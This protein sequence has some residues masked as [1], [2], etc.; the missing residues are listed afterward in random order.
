DASQGSLVKSDPEMVEHLRAAYAMQERKLE[1]PAVEPIA[2]SG[3][4]E[5]PV[6][7]PSKGAGKPPRSKASKKKP[8]VNDSLIS[9]T[10]PDTACVRKKTGGTSRPRYKAHRSVDDEHG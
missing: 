8:R 10:D 3:N 9:S 1:C 2:S 6:P 7:P 5:A 4:G